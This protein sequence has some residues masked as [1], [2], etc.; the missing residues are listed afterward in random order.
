MMCRRVSVDRDRDAQGV[1][2]CP[3]VPAPVEIVKK[4]NSG[5]A[6]TLKE[7]AALAYFVSQ[8][9]GERRGGGNPI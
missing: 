9:G 7:K 8:T 5:E 1:R 2:T 4:E 3:T 6:V